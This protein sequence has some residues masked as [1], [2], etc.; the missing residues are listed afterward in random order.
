L[1]F[2]DFLQDRSV[3][4]I[5]G[6]VSFAGVTL[7]VVNVLAKRAKCKRQGINKVVEP[8]R[9]VFNAETLPYYVTHIH[10]DVT[11]LIVRYRD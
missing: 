10:R 1:D 5:S 6:L 2:E 8:G 3:V 7:V 11:K 4:N 9:D